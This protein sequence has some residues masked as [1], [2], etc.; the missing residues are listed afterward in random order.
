MYAGKEKG[1]HTG[2]PLLARGM[3]CMIHSA[4][5][6]GLQVLGRLC[7]A[8]QA[9]VGQPPA[10]ARF[11]AGEVE[12]Q[13]LVAVLRADVVCNFVGRVGPWERKSRAQ[14]MMAL[15]LRRQ[16]VHTRTRTYVNALLVVAEVQAAGRAVLQERAAER[17]RLR[18][19][20]GPGLNWMQFVIR[21]G[22]R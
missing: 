3:Q 16:S 8:L 18:L 2:M 13:G 20:V 14:P 21:T 12:G 22:L 5:H 10:V 1:T 11:G 17:Q 4:T 19:V 6:H 9:F 7:V 15:L